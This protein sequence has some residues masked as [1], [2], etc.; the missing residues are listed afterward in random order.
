MTVVV[1]TSS[2]MLTVERPSSASYLPLQCMFVSQVQLWLFS[3]IHD[4][5]HSQPTAFCL[6]WKRALWHNLHYAPFY[7][8]GSQA[9]TKNQLLVLR[10]LVN[11]FAKE[12]GI[13]LMDYER[14]WVTIFFTITIVI[15]MFTSWLFLLFMQLLSQVDCLFS[16]SNRANQIALATL[17]Y[18]WVA[19]CGKNGP[20]M[21]L[22]S[23]S[24]AIINLS[25]Y[26]YC[27][28][29]SKS[30]AQEGIPDCIQ[31]AAKVCTVHTYC[32][33]AS[34]ETMTPSCTSRN[35]LSLCCCSLGS[36]LFIW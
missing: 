9:Q 36:Q 14:S 12:T 18:K 6:T 8:R 15:V 32:M 5:L 25:A 1:S 17:I 20:C 16:T 29:Y 3:M 13:Q 28:H 30:K 21:F 23:S 34:C 27:H 26:S 31:Y 10:S 4:K 2:V 7:Y 22:W 24:S 35:W 19:A 33:L 11:I